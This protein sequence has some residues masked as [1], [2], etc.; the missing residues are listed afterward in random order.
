MLA[1]THRDIRGMRTKYL[2]G[3]IHGLYGQRPKIT[4]EERVDDRTQDLVDRLIET[5]Q[6]KAMEK[7]RERASQVTVSAPT[8][9]PAPVVQAEASP[10]DD[11]LE[12]TEEGAWLDG[13]YLPETFTQILIELFE[14]DVPGFVKYAERWYHGSEADA[15][16]DLL[17]YFDDMLYPED[18]QYVE[19]ALVSFLQ[20]KHRLWSETQCYRTIDAYVR[21][22]E[23]C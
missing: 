22:Y 20:T 11:L 5:I 21:M 9:V 8:P 13:V 7:V 6:Q 3:I 16:L 12:L 15:I 19:Q 10:I 23:E 2:R 18:A 1:T 17:D 14:E 4:R